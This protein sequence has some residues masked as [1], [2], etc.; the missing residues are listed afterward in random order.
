MI[1][2]ARIALV[3]D[4]DNTVLGSRIDFAGI[5]RDLVSVLRAA[6][7][8]REPEDALLRSAIADLVA[9]G[10][11]HDRARGT[12]L[13]PQMWRIVEAHEA[14]G[15]K[16][17]A[18]L[19]GAPGVLRALRHRGYRVAILTNNAR[20]AALAA[21]RSAGLAACVE[22]VV[23]RDDAPALKPAGG[24]VREALRRLGEIERAYVIGDSWID[25]AAAAA[26]GAAFIAYRR[27]ADE[28][29]ARGLTPWR[30]IAHLEDLLA[31]DLGG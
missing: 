13:V 14:E 12:D 21:L 29:R 23:A 1:A 7:A 19:D 20:E 31:F 9:R 15:L 3:F 4:M 18:A 30:V 17:A 25:G 22:T 28:L 27:S 2:P 26:A 5:R 16:D 8:T 24:G 6:G 11:A 10:A